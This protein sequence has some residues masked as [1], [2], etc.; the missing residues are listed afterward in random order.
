M[1]IRYLRTSTIAKEL[2][3][4]VNT[5]RL[6]E[7]WGFLPPIPRGDARFSDAPAIDRV[8][9]L[10]YRAELAMRLNDHAL[11][12]SSLAAAQALT[13]TD[14]E[15]ATIA[16]ELVRTVELAAEHG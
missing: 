16:E 2:G 11:A 3:V 12:Q 8:R 10:L 5:I 14:D 1:A 4:H 9:A 6:Y 13:L 15:T 7:T